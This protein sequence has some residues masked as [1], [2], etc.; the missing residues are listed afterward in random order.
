MNR[1]RAK[2]NRTPDINHF[3]P[4]RAASQWRNPSGPSKLACRADSHS[5]RRRKRGRRSTCDHYT[6]AETRIVSDIVD[7]RVFLECAN[8]HGHLS[9]IR[10]K[11]KNSL[12]PRD[13]PSTHISRS[14]HPSSR[15]QSFFFS[16]ITRL[17]KWDAWLL[18]GRTEKKSFAR[19]IPR[20]VKGIGAEA[21]V[22]VTV[23]PPFFKIPDPGHTYL[24]AVATI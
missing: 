19:N 9:E 10:A 24:A 1:C 23:A 5:L 12:G 14:R 3:V 7:G 22:A 16:P 13:A 15:V 17:S 18:Y 4:K 6:R 8:T 2:Q 20:R 11:L 21:A